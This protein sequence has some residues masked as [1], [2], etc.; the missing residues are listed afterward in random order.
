MD[1]VEPHGVLCC[2]LERKLRNDSGLE[3]ES[4]TEN[5]SGNHKIDDQP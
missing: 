4:E 1:D 5:R 3:R 2:D